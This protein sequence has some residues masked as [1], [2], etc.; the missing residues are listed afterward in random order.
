ME[1]L[2]P[3]LFSF[4]SPYG[5]CPQCHGLGSVRTFSPE[6]VVPDPSQPVYAAIAPWSEKDN[7]YYL[8][9]LYNLGQAYGFEIQTLWNQLTSQQQHIILYGAEKS[10]WIEDRKDYRRYAGVIPILQQQYSQASSELIKQ[11]LE[12]YL[13]DRPCE[14]CQGKRLKP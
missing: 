8:S 3:R 9:L 4:N 12:Q 10:I 11:K 1:E 7:S 5:A 14:V 2:S 6:V 13:V